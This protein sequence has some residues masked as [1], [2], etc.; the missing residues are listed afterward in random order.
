[1]QQKVEALLKTSC[2]FLE[3]SNANA[4]LGTYSFGI[5]FVFFCFALVDFATWKFVIFSVKF[6]GYFRTDDFC[7][8]IFVHHLT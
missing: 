2:K 8:V 1:M 3:Y 4:L 7:F 6:I 5:F